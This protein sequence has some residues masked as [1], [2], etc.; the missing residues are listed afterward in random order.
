M[1]I[2][3]VGSPFFIN[4]K[5]VH[6]LSYCAFLD[7]L[8]FSDRIRESYKSK[9]QDVLLEKFHSIL[10]E[11]IDRL[12]MT[13]K[14][15][16]FY[17]KSFTDNVVMAQPRF[18]EDLESEF[19]IILYALKEYQFN[20]VREGFFVRG[21]LSIGKLFVDDNSVY[22][23]AL[24]EAYELESK[25]AV[26]PIVVL[27]DDS[28]KLV[29]RHLTYYNEMQPP[30]VRHLLRSPDGRYFV[31][32]LAESI[33]EEDEGDVLEVNALRK[34]RDSVMS[35]LEKH[36]KNPRVFDKFLWLASYHNYFCDQVSNYSGYKSSLK[37]PR[38]HIS[39]NFSLIVNV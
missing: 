18:S 13:S 7:V 17:F 8:G 32:Y 38:K 35:E 25:C 34:H 3:G 19:A 10:G 5:P 4:G 9:S 39:I 29:N 22:G 1:S 23:E 26:N 15:T 24:L 33:R 37:I 20:M 21:G 27:S 14:D 28:M 31:N 16:T 30:Q 12:K 36:R 6:R 11:S 2:L